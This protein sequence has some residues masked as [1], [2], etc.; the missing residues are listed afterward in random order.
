MRILI[1]G[2]G[3]IGCYYGA[4]LQSSG[5]QV[6]FVARGDHLTALQQQGLKVNHNDFSF[7]QSVNAVDETSLLKAFK[8][9]DFDLIIL[10]FKAFDTAGWLSRMGEWLQTATTPVLSLQNGV[11]NEALIAEKIGKDRTLGGLAVRIGGH[12]IEPGVVAADGPAQV[13]MGAWP[14]QQQSQ[15]NNADLIQIQEHFLSAGIPTRISDNIEQELWRKLLINN[16]VNPLSAITGLTTRGLVESKHFE[17]CVRQLMQEVVLVAQ[18]EG[19]NLTHDDIEEMI[20]LLK[21]FDAIKTSMLVD[22]EKG[23][24]IELD[25]ICGSLLTRA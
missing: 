7:D 15:Y 8:A 24:P 5:D 21:N 12:I 23:K 10:C 16:G 2:A 25:A 18:Q 13:V 14:S 20:T 3:G 22:H 4:R 19:I 1:V 6:V 17:P 11:D 9:N